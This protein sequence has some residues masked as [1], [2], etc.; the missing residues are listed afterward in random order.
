MKL[1]FF[2]VFMLFVTVVT[3]HQTHAQIVSGEGY[4]LR[5]A[6]DVWFNAV[7]GILLGAR[8]RGEDPRTFL[9]GPHRLSAGFSLAT[10]LPDTPVSYHISYTHPI[11]AITA[12]RSEGAVRLFSSMRA[13]VHLHE[14]GIRKRWQR[15]FDEF[16]ATDVRF[17][18]GLY[19]RF[20]DDYLIY[21]DLW[22]DDPVLFVRSSVRRRDHNALGRWT[23]RGAAIAGAPLST[24]AQFLDYSG[25]PADRPDGTGPEGLFGQLQLELLNQIGISGPFYARTRLFAG[26]SSDALPPEHRYLPSDAAPFALL[27]SRFT[28]ARGTIPQGWVESGWIHIPGG[29]GLRGYSMQTAEALETAGPPWVRHAFSGNIDIYYPNPVDTYFSKIPYLG[30]LL[31]F[32]SYVFADAGLFHDHNGW[33][34]VQANAGAGFMLSLN[35]P[36]YMGRNRGFFIRY[37]LPVWLSEPAGEDS[38]LDVRHLLGVG[39]QF[40]F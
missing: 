33:Q 15:G 6:P 2:C 14:A 39:A 37:E 8:F 9:D 3:T 38:A 5:V 17:D 28:R 34:Q 21:N 18:A 35:I 11:A 23:F 27:D 32:E 40:L 31:R 24:D 12:P 16:V 29:P 36:D 26:F 30:D 19:K 1:F 25:L 13:G 7:D 10:W 22:Q 20:D 4:E